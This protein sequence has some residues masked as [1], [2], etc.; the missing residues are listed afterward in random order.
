M[1]LVG[2]LREYAIIPGTYEQGTRKP[3]LFL[4]KLYGLRDS[5]RNSVYGQQ[6][7]YYFLK[8]QETWNS[9]RPNNP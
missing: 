5:F 7:E 3:G 6:A 8:I 4:N 9:L 1:S 2:I